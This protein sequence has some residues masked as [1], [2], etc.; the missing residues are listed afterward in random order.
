MADLSIFV[1]ES[2]D[3]GEYSPHSPY[4]IVT[5]VIHDQEK[6]IAPQIQKLDEEIQSLGYE[7][8][9]SYTQPRLSEK[10]KCSI[11]NRQTNAEPCSQNCF[12]LP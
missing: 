6:D 2:G 5:M 3:F 10:K 12:I 8:I 9:L 11:P 1:D 4:Y 7:K